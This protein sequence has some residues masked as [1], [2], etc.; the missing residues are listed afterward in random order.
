MKQ[1]QPLIALKNVG[2]KYKRR[3]KFKKKAFW[4][5][6][7]IDLEIYKGETLGII[8]HNGAGKSTL[9]KV[10]ANLMAPDEG[11]HI[12]NTNM[13]AGILAL[14]AGFTSSLSGRDNIM[15][16]AMFLGVSKAYIQSKKDDIIKLSGI[17]EFIDNPVN[18]YSTGMT[19]RL[20]FSIAYHCAPDILLLDEILGVGDAEFKKLSKKL[21]VEMVHSNKTIV[22]VSHDEK[23]IKELCTR[24]I[25]LN[26][27]HQ[28]ASAQQEA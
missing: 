12:R 14:K 21:I 27:G 17:E 6:Q 5:L 10:I 15:L 3:G 11:E 25:R 24:V 19:A 20:G 9:L 2:I 28:I 22:L 1:Q 23:I 7:N 16:S 18:S 26:K 8:G 13:R 4:A